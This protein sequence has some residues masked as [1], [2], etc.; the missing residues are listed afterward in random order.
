[1]EQGFHQKIGEGHGV[2]LQNHGK[3]QSLSNSEGN[4]KK[5]VEGKPELQFMVDS[6]DEYSFESDESNEII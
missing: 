5:L 3:R 4:Y 2:P 1:M 6:E